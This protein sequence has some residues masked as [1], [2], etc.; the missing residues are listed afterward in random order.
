MSWRSKAAW[1]VGRVIA[2][3]KE[4]PIPEIRRALRDAYPWGLRRNYPYRIWLSEC[5]R[6]LAREEQ[7]RNPEM[8][9]EGLPL[10]Q[11]KSEQEK[12]AD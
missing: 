1:L 10:F 9:I 12:G 5:H 4:R 8:C 6:Q 7:L 11:K 3:H 2:K